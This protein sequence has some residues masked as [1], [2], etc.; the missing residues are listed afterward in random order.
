[1]RFHGVVMLVGGLVGRIDLDRRMGELPGEVATRRGRLGRGRVAVIK[2]G[3]QVG[4]VR[5]LA[6]LDADQRACVAGQLEVFRHHQC[7][8]LPAVQHAVIEQWAKGRAFGRVCVAVVIVVTGNPRTVGMVQHGDDAGYLERL[9]AV[10][11]KHP[12]TGD[13][14]ADDAAMQQ[15]GVGVFAG[16]A[17]LPGDLCQAIDTVY[18]LADNGGNAIHGVAPG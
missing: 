9:A 15:A 11:A 16:I 1:M 17:S 13:G 6:V 10:D 3:Q 5:L 8:R 18:G 7:Q 4:L 12:A 14:A 2:D